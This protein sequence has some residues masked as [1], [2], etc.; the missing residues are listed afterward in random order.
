[1]E[2]NS[3]LVIVKR[4][5][6]WAYFVPF[7][8]TVTA[9]DFAYIFIET[10]FAQYRMPKEIILD[11]DKLFT[12]QFWQLLTDQLGTKHK[13]LTAFH[14]QTD[15]QTER[16]N[17]VLEQYLQY[18]LDYEQTKWVELLPTAQ[19]AYNNSAGATGISPYYANYRKHLRLHDY[20]LGM[21]PVAEKAKIL[22]THLQTMHQ[23]LKEDL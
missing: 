16:T 4:L 2:Y 8:Q 10:V 5:T 17:Q 7:L 3:I 14:P 22:V 1:M 18:Y 6:K 9:T 15:G 11:R 19:F 21:K 20:K 12:S 23:L 13:L